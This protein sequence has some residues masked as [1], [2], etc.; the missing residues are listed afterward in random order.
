MTWMGGWGAVLLILAGASGEAVP[1]RHILYLHGRIVQETQS[2]RPVHP[3]FGPYDL[4]AI[5]ETL[6]SRGFVVTGGIRPK[7]ATVSGSADRVVAQVRDLLASGVRADHVTVAGASM[8][9]SIALAAAARLQNDDV[10]F[11]FLGACTTANMN[12]VPEEEGKPPRGRLLFVREESD[13]LSGPCAAW[14]GEAPPGSV[15]RE[16]VLKTGLSH[17]FI[18]RPLPAW[19]DPAVAWARGEEAGSP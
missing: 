3:E 2:A 19:V 1:P 14:S 17:G 5:L 12:A 9:A 15:V 4:D 6:C 13:D 16:V 10:R 18:Y 11:V 8:G 7:A